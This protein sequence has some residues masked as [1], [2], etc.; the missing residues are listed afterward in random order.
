VLALALEK[1][2]AV[3]LLD[4][5]LARRIARAAGLTVWG[6]LKIL[7]EAKAYGLTSSVAPLIDRLTT[8]GMW[9]SDDVRQRI[10]GLAGEA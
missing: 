1:Q 7:L 10:L 3:V 2:D 5:A 4:D 6:T 8:A 9:I